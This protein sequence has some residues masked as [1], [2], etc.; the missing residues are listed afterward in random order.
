MSKTMKGAKKGKQV[1]GPL[2]KGMKKG[3]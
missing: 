1:A 2:K 3:C